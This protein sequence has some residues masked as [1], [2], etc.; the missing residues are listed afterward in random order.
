MIN[1][2]TYIFNR[3]TTFQQWLLILLLV[4]YYEY[5]HSLDNYHEYERGEYDD[6]TNYNFYYIRNQLIY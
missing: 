1:N 4:A 6:N 3:L 2:I 5:L